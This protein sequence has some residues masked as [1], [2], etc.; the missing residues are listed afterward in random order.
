L[1]EHWNDFIK[2]AE[3][4]PDARGQDVEHIKLY[5][6]VHS[7]SQQDLKAEEPINTTV[8]SQ[9]TS[10]TWAQIRTSYKSFR[11][12]DPPGIHPAIL[13]IL[14]QQ[15]TSDRKVIILQEGVA[16]WFTPDG[17]YADDTMQDR[18]DLER[19]TVWHKYRVP[20]EEAWI[21]QCALEGFCGLESAEPWFE[22]DLMGDVLV[23]PEGND[24]E[25]EE[26]DE[27]EDGTTSEDLEYM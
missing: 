15:S 4:P 10:A 24:D 14:D 5:V 22:K 12:R 27:D 6:L 21:V 9:F 13:L 7:P 8:K 18:E 16:E 1:I 3:I 23:E 17:N 2:T 26:T 25:E 19:K 20:F 11:A